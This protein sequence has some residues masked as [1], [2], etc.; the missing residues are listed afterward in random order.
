MTMQKQIDQFLS[1]AAFG[2]VGA[3]SNRH[4]FGNKVLRCYIQNGKTAVPVN[5][6]EAEIE[7]LAC[8]KSVEEL[9]P[10]VKSIS[11]ITPPAVTEQLVPLAIAHGVENIWM[12]PGAESPAAVA[13]CR[14]KGINVIADGSCLLVVMGYH[15]H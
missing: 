10:E 15:D 13:L 11:M 8:V 5:P 6:N 7:G 12:Q 1:S 2:V 9:P 4:K 3:S 14:E